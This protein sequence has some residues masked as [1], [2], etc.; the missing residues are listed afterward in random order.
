MTEIRTRTRTRAVNLGS[1]DKEPVLQSDEGFIHVTRVIYGD[2]TEVVNDRVRVPVFHTAP[3]RVRVGGG[4]TRN[5]GDFNSAR[6]DVVVE[7]PCYP[8]KTEI[9]RAGAYAA[10]LVDEFLSEEMRKAGFN[11]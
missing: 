6:F 5:Q 1:T 11:V 9:L 3:A 8:E 4:V 10:Q 2:E 7:L